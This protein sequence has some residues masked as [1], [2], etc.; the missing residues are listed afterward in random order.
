MRAYQICTR[1]IMDTS[2]PDI[3]FNEEG[4]C[5]HCINFETKAVRN[6][7]PNEEGRKKL[8]LIVEKIKSENK[9]REYD[10]ILG[11][12]GGVDSSYLAYIAR[13]V[14]NL[15]ML[16]VHVDAGW[17]S[18][19]AVKNIETMVKKL[20]IDLYTH[21]VDWDEMQDLQVAY[22]KSGLANQ[23]V[24]Q[25]H[26]F[27]SV[28]YDYAHKNG[29]KYVLHGSNIATE[30]ILPKSW[31]YKAMDAKQL[32]AVHKRFGKVKLKSYKTVG[33]FKYEIY[34]PTLLRMKVVR[35]LNFLPYNKDD[36]IKTLESELGWKYYGGKHYESRFTKFFQSY[37][38]PTRFGFD[39][40]R[41]HLSSLVVSG[42]M[43]REDALKEMA[44][45]AYSEAELKEDAY[46]VAKKLGITT[47]ELNQYLAAPLKTFKDYPSNYSL[48]C[49]LKRLKG[50][51]RK[52]RCPEDDSS[53]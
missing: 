28:L 25:D 13:K 43:T 24:P 32:K 50:I 27:F 51:L 16:A 26:I 49:L 38:L 14:F 29:I 34:Y 9:D 42:Q 40:R 2:D 37:Y 10:C 33:F 35:M 23:D 41:A 47:D 7:F 1:C 53:T 12:S 44:K 15:R 36:A 22:L 3:S 48:D 19:I 5:S 30:S 4:V 45:P 6:W 52:I 46:F 21:V 18:E 17:N 31:G 20:G 11:L 39:K 8:D